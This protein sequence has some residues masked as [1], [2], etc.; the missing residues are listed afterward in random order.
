MK[1]LASHNALKIWIRGP[2]GSGK[3][4]LLVEKVLRLTEEILCRKA[5]EKILI[6]CFNR[7]LCKALEKNIKMWF[8]ADTNVNHILHF[9]TLAK[10]VIDVG[11]LPSAP[12]T[13][14]EKEHAIN[15][16]LECL[17]QNASPFRG[18]Y[19][20]IFVDEGQDFYGLNWTKLLEQMHK[21]SFLSSDGVLQKPGFFWVMYDLNQYLYFARERANLN[22]TNLKSSAELNTVFRNTGNV[23]MQSMKYFKSLMQNDSTVTG[24][25]HE[26]A[27]LPI[28][29]DD[30]LQD[31]NA[32]E[33][34]GA[35]SIANGRKN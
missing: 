2:A 28:K 35:L 27:G 22:F 18:Y 15:C 11:N 9:K 20:H 24:L 1:I 16:A 5:T 17:E 29:W 33:T 13:S 8:P 10:L 12:E 3:T 32:Y 34:E 26:E 7:L 31:R 4:C 14:D 30:S 6:V 19:D 23:F 25:G 21:S